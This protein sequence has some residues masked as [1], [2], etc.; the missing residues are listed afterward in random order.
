MRS[1]NATI[2][3]C[4]TRLAE[5]RITGLLTLDR[6]SAFCIKNEKFTKT[7]SQLPIDHDPWP[8][9]AALRLKIDHPNSRSAVYMKTRN[10]KIFSFMFSSA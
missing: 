2:N 6:K 5:K 9:R 7:Y 8:S 3:L 4:S 1:A 10:L